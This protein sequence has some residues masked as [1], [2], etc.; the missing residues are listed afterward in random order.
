MVNIDLL[1]TFIK[2]LKITSGFEF[3]I[4]SLDFFDSVTPATGA[5]LKWSSEIG[6]GYSG[7]QP[8][9]KIGW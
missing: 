6:I 1:R 3:L 7:D 2:R 5:L 4:S 9:M 8:S